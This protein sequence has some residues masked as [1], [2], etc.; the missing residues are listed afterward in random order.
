[1]PKNFLNN[2]SY[3]IG[4]RNNNPGNLK[5][6]GDN[7]VGM[8]GTN[9]G[10]VTFKDMSY[11]LRAMAIDLSNK[12][13]NG[14]DTIRKIITR[15]APPS[16]NDTE[17]YIRAMVQY[18]GIGENEKLIADFPTLLK[19]MKG[20][21]RH[22]NGKQ[23]A[24]LLTDADLTEGINMMPKSIID[25]VANFFGTTVTGAQKKNISTVLIIVGVLGIVLIS[26]AL[27]KK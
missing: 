25:R 14:F 1:M 20:I 10:F 5:A 8:I 11:G 7:W 2:P 27:I 16:E 18:T 13:N 19:L 26:T 4:F 9:G 21:I 12:I 17:A 3:P 23:F 6:S 15:W 22:E 24:D